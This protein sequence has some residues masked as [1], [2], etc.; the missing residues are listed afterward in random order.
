VLRSREYLTPEEAEQ[1]ITAAGK[2]GRY[3]HRDATLLM[4]AY[5]HGLRVGELVALRW[6]QVDLKAG[7]LHVT[8]LKKGLPSTHPLRGPELRALR[9]LQRE[10]SPPSPYVFTTERRGPLTTS[11]VRKIVAMAGEAAG[12]PFRVHPHMLRH[13]CGF[14][15]ANEGHDTRAIQQYLGHKNITHTV[16]YTELAP[17]RFKDF[18]KD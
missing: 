17:G 3:G 5:R 8:R 1:L 16:R 13:G 9:R 10:Q 18:W 6:E 12:L 14:K 11:A 15:L 4:L 2:R 7:L